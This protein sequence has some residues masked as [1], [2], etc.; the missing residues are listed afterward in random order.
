MG[1]QGF[2]GA[3]ARGFGRGFVQNM[4]SAFSVRMVSSLAPSALA[5]AFRQAALT[6]VTRGLFAAAPYIMG[7]I[8]SAIGIRAVGS[9]LGYSSPDSAYGQASAAHDPN[10]WA[11]GLGHGLAGESPESSTQ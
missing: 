6:P 9:P 7:P 11:N 3:F 10:A 1:G 8:G 5:T 4:A 2:L